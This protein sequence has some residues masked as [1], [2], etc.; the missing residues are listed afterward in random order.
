MGYGNIDSGTLFY[1]NTAIGTISATIGTIPNEIR[2]KKEDWIIYILANVFITKDNHYKYIEY[3]K[4]VEKELI[5]RG[6]VDKKTKELVLN[7]DFTIYGFL[8]NYI[9]IFDKRIILL[10]TEQ[11][12]GI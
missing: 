2:I 5:E 9:D 4:L 8:T 1:G 3:T 11:L 6:Y 7:A 12:K 10:I